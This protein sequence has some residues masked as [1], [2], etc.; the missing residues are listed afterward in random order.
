M[1]IGNNTFNPNANNTKNK[2]SSIKHNFNMAQ[3]KQYKD[4]NNRNE[5][6]DQS[7]A[8][9]QDRYNNGLISYEDFIKQCDKI[10]KLRK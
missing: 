9:L 3:Q 4:V 2:I 8:V 6:L 1:I 5:M 7:L 10:G